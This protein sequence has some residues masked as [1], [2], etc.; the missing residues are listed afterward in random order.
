[1]EQLRYSY[2]IVKLMEDGT[3]F[4][5]VVEIVEEREDF[6]VAEEGMCFCIF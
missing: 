3:L 6:E 1:M 4:L 5:K 2:C